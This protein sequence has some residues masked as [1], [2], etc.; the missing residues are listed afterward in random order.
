M[1]V[2]RFNSHKFLIILYLVILL[3]AIVIDMNPSLRQSFLLISPGII[4]LV[5]APIL[6]IYLARH[7]STNTKTRIIFYSIIIFI[8]ILPKISISSKIENYQIKKSKIA[9]MKLV[10][11]LHTYF[12]KFKKYPKSLNKLVPN[13]MKKIPTTSMGVFG[14]HFLYELDEQNGFFLKFVLSDG[15]ICFIT[16]KHKLW[17]ID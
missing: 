1:K 4:L 3:V 10:T 15:Y 8:S 14:T 12:R 16:S 11:N 17:K 9:G 13:F 5:I 2:E 6:L 7:S